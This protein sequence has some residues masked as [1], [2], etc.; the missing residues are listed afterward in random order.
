MNEKV[1]TRKTGDMLS[2]CLKG[3]FMLWHGLHDFCPAY[4]NAASPTIPAPTRLPT[5]V[6]IAAPAELVELPELLP[7]PPPDAP[8]DPTPAEPELVGLYGF[9]LVTAVPS[10]PGYCPPGL[11]VKFPGTFV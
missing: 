4:I 5:P 10:P 8:P 3:V 2:E 6:I 7:D 11:A 1:L 9:P